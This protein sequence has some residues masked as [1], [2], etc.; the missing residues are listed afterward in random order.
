LQDKLIL[1][2]TKVVSRSPNALYQYGDLVGDVQGAVISQANGIVTFRFVHGNGKADPKHEVQYQDW[3]L[4]CP[5]LPPHPPADAN[6]GGID[7]A[8]APLTC[9]IMRK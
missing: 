8:I 4:S 7:Q 2:R 9:T 5:E 6:I 3:L 1:E